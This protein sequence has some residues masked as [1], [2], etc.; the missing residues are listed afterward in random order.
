VQTLTGHRFYVLDPEPED[1]QIADISGSL[2]KIC[3]FNGHPRIP[4]YIGQHCVLGSH[5]VEEQTHNLILALAFLLHDSGEAYLTDMVRPLKVMPE[6]EAYRLASKRLDRVIEKRFNL[7]EGILDHQVIKETD[8]RMLFTE[9]RDLLV[10]L[11]WDQSAQPYD[12]KIKPWSWQKA[13]K[14]YLFRYHELCL[15]LDGY[16]EM[17]TKALS[18]TRLLPVVGKFSTRER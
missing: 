8:N 6:L 18:L 4:Y 1:I 14:R 16:P 13:Q 5:V 11:Q 15:R 17:A 7:P 2:G 9:K 3:R 10:A 12:F